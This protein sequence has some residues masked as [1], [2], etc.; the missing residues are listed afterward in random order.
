[1]L[2]PIN[3]LSDHLSDHTSR[4]PHQQMAWVN[5]KTLYWSTKFS[6][7]S[8]TRAFPHGDVATRPTVFSTLFA[9]ASP[10]SPLRPGHCSATRKRGIRWHPCVQGFRRVFRPNSSK[11]LC[12]LG[13]LACSCC[14]SEFIDHVEGFD[15][16]FG[17]QTACYKTPQFRS[18]SL[19]P[20]IG[21]F[22][23]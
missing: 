13:I 23:A 12:F 8:D 14:F 9:T 21:S 4:S 18:S 16:L 7:F 1:M 5:Q 6:Y 2:T 19:N 17:W 15:H 20:V 22:L 11:A 10:A 3:H